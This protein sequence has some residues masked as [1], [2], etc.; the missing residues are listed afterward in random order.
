MDPKALEQLL[1]QA[2]GHAIRYRS[3][4]GDGPQ[5]A[6]R[7]FLEMREAFSAPVPETGSDAAELIDQLVRDAEPGLN[8]MTGPR[9][10]GW[11]I[12]ASHPVGVAADWL[13]SAWGQNT[14]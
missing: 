2:A 13:T 14:G 10:F 7:S 1:L 12:G 3:H 5:G 11:V 6:R 9:F 4:V 8:A